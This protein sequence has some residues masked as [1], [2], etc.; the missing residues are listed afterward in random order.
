MQRSMKHARANNGV[1]AHVELLMRERSKGK[2]FRKQ[3]CNAEPVM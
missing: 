1:L 2:S 3:N